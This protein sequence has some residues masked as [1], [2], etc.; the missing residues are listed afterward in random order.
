MPPPDAIIGHTGFV[1]SILCHQRA[2]QRQFNS[3]NIDQIRYETFGTV[4]C[5][6]AP[7]SM[8]TANR[9]PDRDEAAIAALIEHLKKMQAEC[10]VLISSIAVLADF[11]SGSDEDA[12]DFQTTLAYGRHRRMLEEF[13]ESHFERSLIVRLPALFGP[14]LRKNFI[15]DLINPVPSMLTEARFKELFDRLSVEQAKS[16]RAYYHPN[17]ATGMVVLDRAAFDNDPRCHELGAA[18][19]ALEMSSKQFHNPKAEYQYYDLA[20]LWSDIEVASKA[21]LSNVHLAVAPLRADA[22]HQCLLG[23]PMPQTGARLH[24]EDMRTKHAALWG[25]DGPYLEEAEVVLDKL[26]DFYAHETNAP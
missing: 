24:K 5:A 6:A 23:K 22:I 16:L 26:T 20:R 17:A 14:G 21:E 18:V 4:V 3:K 1:G 7:G 10:L 15:F 8:V 9:D 2:F 12:D 13:C 19:D 11:A 25:K